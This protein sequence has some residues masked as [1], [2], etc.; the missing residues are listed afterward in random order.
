MAF[1]QNK[2]RACVCT[3][4]CKVVQYTYPHT[5]TQITINKNIR[6]VEF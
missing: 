1:L 6:E 4:A 2:E 5:G 3:H